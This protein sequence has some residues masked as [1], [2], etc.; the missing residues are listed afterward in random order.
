M[1]DMG[2]ASGKDTGLAMKRIIALLCCLL[3]LTALSPG[4]VLAAD[5]W[6]LVLDDDIVSVSGSTP[7]MSRGSKVYLP[8]D[9]VLGFM[10]CNYIFD[11]NTFAVFRGNVELSFNMETG[12]CI[13]Y[14]TA[15]RT[16]RYFTQQ[17]FF[18]NGTFYIPADFVAKEIGYNYTTLPNGI[19]RIRSSLAKMSDQQVETA[20][21]VEVPEI[22]TAEKKNLTFYTAV[23]AHDGENVGKLLSVLKRTDHEAVFFLTEQDMLYM[24]DAVRRI[25]VE[26]QSVGILLSEELFSGGSVTDEA[27]LAAAEASNARLQQITKSRT[28][29]ILWPASARRAV[30]KAQRDLLIDLGYRFWSA[31]L[32]VSPNY[33]LSKLSDYLNAASRGGLL[34]F[35][36]GGGA[37]SRLSRYFSSLS[38][39][40]YRSRPPLAVF[41]PANFWN[42]TR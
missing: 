4:M 12:N 18:E 10:G 23:T 26:G 40:E 20:L 38:E 31:S 37:D 13:A 29:L 25:L 14:N 19:I 1:R 15:T 9:T 36:G 28:N 34:L 24:P 21:T 17:V 32:T 7:L 22:E 33:S 16:S 2:A 5:D 42:D 8:A 41:T 27:L 30:T 6:T 3:L 35:E 11:G 39:L